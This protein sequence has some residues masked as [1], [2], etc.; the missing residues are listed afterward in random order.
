M[1]FA[2]MH[3][4]AESVQGLVS[5]LEERWLEAY[6]PAAEQWCAEMGALH[7][8]EVIDEADAFAE[9]L[10]LKP[11]EV[12]R[13]LGPKRSPRG[14]KATEAPQAPQAP[15]AVSPRPVAPKP[16]AKKETPK[17]P[18]VDD[19]AT[20]TA[21]STCTTRTEPTA[22]GFRTFVSKK[23]AKSATS[24]AAS[25]CVSEVSTVVTTKASI[26]K[27]VMDTEATFTTI[28]ARQVGALMG[29]KGATLSKIEA[30]NRVKVIVPKEGK[31][32]AIV[33]RGPGKKTVD[34]A[35]EICKARIQENEMDSALEKLDVDE[36]AEQVAVDSCDIGALLGKGG[37][38]LRRIEEA[39]KA[40]IA[41]S[42]EGAVRSV[43]VRGTAASV[44]AA[45]EAIADVL[46]FEERTVEV[47]EWAVGEILGSG[48]KAVAKLQRETGARVDVAEAVPGD[49]CRLVRI[50]ARTPHAVAAAEE[51][52]LRSARPVE[53]SIEVTSTEAG[54][55]IGRKGETVKAIQKTSGARLTI[56][57]NGRVRTVWIT[58]PTIDN[59]NQALDAMRDVLREE[60]PSERKTRTASPPRSAQSTEA[61][62]MN[63]VEFPALR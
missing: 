59:I 57:Q 9:A 4:D 29:P 56:D 44:S 16:V 3:N 49:E 22:D 15:K 55:L 46:R 28:P 42:K 23:S 5:Y 12:K 39:T 48:G 31:T 2:V 13:L 25:T 21:P 18:Q 45:K 14:P 53:H 40:R 50:R 58:G 33:I 17:A 8:D 32:R 7:I 35:V 63:A 60:L 10:G 36:K 41:V 37:A 54:V 61:P 19:D 30:D 43:V 62:E 1:S 11:L 47:P 6:V 24:D 26:L 34:R 51:A 52:I 20:S 38:T 27:P